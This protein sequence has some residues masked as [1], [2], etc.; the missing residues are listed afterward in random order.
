[1][2]ARV[3]DNV[4]LILY[5]VP[6]RKDLYIGLAVALVHSDVMGWAFALHAPSTTLWLT[7]LQNVSKIFSGNWRTVGSSLIPTGK[8][9]HE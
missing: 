4:L 6:P 3:M 5:S 2:D 1:M 7:L 8:P 9:A